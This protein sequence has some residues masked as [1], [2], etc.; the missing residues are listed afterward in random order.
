MKREFL[1]NTEQEGFNVLKLMLEWA[2]K[3][4]LL[5]PL[6]RDKK[7]APLLCIEEYLTNI[8]RYGQLNYPSILT[9]EIEM[10]QPNQLRIL[11]VDSGQFFDL[12]KSTVRK[13][14]DRIGGGGIPLIR[15]LM[16]VKQFH[17]DQKNYTIF[18]FQS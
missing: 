15:S 8:L 17:Q 12:M 4:I 14:H 10:I 2:E 7:W 6:N 16:R 9:I 1:I 11:L 5:M 18:D 3:T 13:D